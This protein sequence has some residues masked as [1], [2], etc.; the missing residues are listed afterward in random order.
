MTPPE[1]ERFILDRAGVN[2]VDVVAAKHFIAKAPDSD[3]LALAQ[4]FVHQRL[5]DLS[6]TVAL[7]GTLVEETLATHARAIAMRLAVFQATWELVTAA[8]LF[9]AGPAVGWTPSLGWSTRNGA[10]GFRL[11]SIRFNYPE[12]VVRPVVEAPSA[13][14]DA[15]LFLGELGLNDINQGIIDAVALAVKC[16]R[17][18]LYLPAL[19]MLAAAAEG[20]WIEAGTAL[21]NAATTR[22]KAVDK[23][24]ATIRDDLAGIGQKVRA[25]VDL[26]SRRDVVRTVRETSGVSDGQLNEAAVWTAVVRD[27]RNALHWNHEEVFRNDYAKTASL[28]MAAGQALRV[29][30]AIRGASRTATSATGTGGA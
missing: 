17:F 6:H 25:V 19:A 9:P 12:K 13:L 22:D 11:D 4:G 27:A 15:D 8:L 7:D 14:S 20:A 18:D 24:L 5:G 26:Y 23:A 28:V 1:A 10:G 2:R 21:A 29:L 3:T 30:E 16:L